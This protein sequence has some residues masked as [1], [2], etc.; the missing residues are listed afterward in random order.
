MNVVFSFL[1]A[2]GA[3]INSFSGDVVDF[4][5]Y[6]TSSQGLPATQYLISAGAGTEPTA[7]TGAKFTVSSYSLVIT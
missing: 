7:G 6:L 1:P 4:V 3:T 5:K 2:N